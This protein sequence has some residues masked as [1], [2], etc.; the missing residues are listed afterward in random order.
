MWTSYSFGVAGGIFDAM[1]STLDIGMAV[2]LVSCGLLGLTG[3]ISR[4]GGGKDSLD[5]P[6]ADV[7]INC[8]GELALSATLS[9]S[10]ARNARLQSFTA[11]GKLRE[12]DD[13]PV[14]K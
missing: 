4:D 8:R 7:L 3:V 13:G 12:A 9:H 14:L 6:D 2:M 11:R 10:T 5:L 1:N